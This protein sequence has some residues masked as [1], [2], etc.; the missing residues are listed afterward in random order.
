M[1]EKLYI[2]FGTGADAVGLIQQ[3]TRPLAEINANIID[4][5]QDVLHGLF[6]VF[7]VVDLTDAARGAEE[8]RAMVGEIAE[9]TGLDLAMDRYQPVAR[10]VEKRNLLLILLGRDRPGII[11]TVS[12]VLSTHRINV[13]SSQMIAREG[14]FLMD[15]MVDVGRSVLPLENLKT[16]LRERMGALGID[17][18]FQSE[19]VFNKK[20]RVLLFELTGSFMDAATRAEVLRQAGIEPAALAAAYLPGDPPRAVAA[21]LARLEGMPVEVL[22]RLVDAV[23]VTPGTLELIQTLKTMGYQVAVLSNALAPFTDGIRQRLGIDA[24]FGVP[25]P[26]NDDAMTF[27]GLPAPEDWQALE[28]DRVIALLSAREGVAR[29]DVTVISD[30]AAGDAAPPGIHVRFDMKLLLDFFNEHVLSRESLI[31]VLGAFGTPGGP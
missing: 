30:R 14:I 23:E 26:V 13:E 8:V 17:A 15:L 9:R 6:T 31:G 16:T 3:I 20:K 21:A 5:R 2:I 24:C 29:E 27:A 19:D 4:L 22:Q 28:R 1:S 11:A 10:G 12:D 7:L 25:V 18:L